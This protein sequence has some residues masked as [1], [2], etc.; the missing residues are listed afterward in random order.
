MENETTLPT[1][2]VDTTCHT[3]GCV[4]DGVTHRVNVPFIA[5]NVLRVIC[6]TCSQAVTDL[7]EV[8]D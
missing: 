5:D 4:N 3:S 2:I 8:H 6:G 1:K 7:V